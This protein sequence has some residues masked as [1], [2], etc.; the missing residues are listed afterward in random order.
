MTDA[1]HLTTAEL[2]AGL[3]AI[4]QSPKD[5]GVCRS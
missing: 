1:R 4:L 3:E 2:E 5:Q